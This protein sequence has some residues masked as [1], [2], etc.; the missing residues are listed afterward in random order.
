VVVQRCIVRVRSRDAGYGVAHTVIERRIRELA[1]GKTYVVPYSVVV[2][3]VIRWKVKEYYEGVSYAQLGAYAC[4]LG[5]VG[6]TFYD[7]EVEAFFG[8]GMSPLLCVAIGRR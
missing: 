2:N 6:S 1:R 5:A 3:N 7:E 8:A 4:D